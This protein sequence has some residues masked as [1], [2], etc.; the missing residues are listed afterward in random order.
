MKDLVIAFFCV[1][2]IFFIVI[3][4]WAIQKS[5]PTV[6]YKKTSLGVDIGYRNIN[7]TVYDTG[8][9]ML[10]MQSLDDIDDAILCLTQAKK[11]L[12]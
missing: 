7:A 3:S 8:Y 4:A 9:V 11:E 5:E 12:L 10:Q 6:R 2:G 1:I